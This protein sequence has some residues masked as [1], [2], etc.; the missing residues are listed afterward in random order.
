ML[1]SATHKDGPRMALPTQYLLSGKNLPDVFAALKNA[2]APER[3]TQTF[4]EQLGFKGTNDR[5]IIGV[6]K[7]LRFLDDAGRPTQRY[8]DFLDQT[9]S[10][11]VVAD[12]VREAYSDLFAIN[13]NAQTMAKQ[14]FIGKV[15]TLSQGQLS[16]VVG[17]VSELV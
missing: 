15:R 12:A 11:R 4:L 9:Q 13:V 10:G 7:A 2:K 6:L 17:G 14:D 5:L 8:F 16:D 3:F 1:L